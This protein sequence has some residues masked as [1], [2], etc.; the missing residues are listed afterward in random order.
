MHFLVGAV[1]D[2]ISCCYHVLTTR[3]LQVHRP[4]AF[5]FKHIFSIRVENS[6]DPDQMASDLDLK[7]FQ[8]MINSGQQDKG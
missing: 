4:A 5:K 7:C 1:I 8:K 3:M 2:V 6:E